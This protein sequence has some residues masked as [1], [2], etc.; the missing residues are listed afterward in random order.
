MKKFG[1]VPNERAILI[2]R[3]DLESECLERKLRGL[4]ADYFIVPMDSNK[5]M[6]L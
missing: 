6:M 2:E 5:I 1:N 3:R 4:R